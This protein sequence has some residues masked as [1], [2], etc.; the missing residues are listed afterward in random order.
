[1]KKIV[2]VLI[3]LLS[4]QTVYADDGITHI[5]INISGAKQD[6]SYFLCLSDIGCLSIKAGNAG[7][8]YSIYNNVQLSGIAVLDID[9]NFRVS[10]QPV[11]ASCGTA[12]S[13]KT[14]TI[15]GN[16]VSGLNQNTV[17]NNLHC[18][19]S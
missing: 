19:I 9:K 14:I 16:L 4:L 3:T 8:V 5:R 18:T 13:N 12:I 10:V 6:N 17:I 11:P 15:S 2:A 7:K 1:M